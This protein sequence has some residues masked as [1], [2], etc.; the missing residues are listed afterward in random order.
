MILRTS[1]LAI[2]RGRKSTVLIASSSELSNSM[3]KAG[4]LFSADS[5][6]ML[7]KRS[8]Y[9]GGDVTLFECATKMKRT[10][11]L[12]CLMYFVV[13]LPFAMAIVVPQQ[14]D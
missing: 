3:S 10:S 11:V 1:Q 14:H 12:V 6:V 13:A 2:V 7:Y 5:P 4:S 9:L 8:G